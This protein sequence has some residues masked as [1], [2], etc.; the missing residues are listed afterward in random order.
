LREPAPGLSGAPGPQSSGRSLR[1]SR[2]QRVNDPQATDPQENQAANVAVLLSALAV[3]LVA[4]LAADTAV[5][6]RVTDE[7]AQGAVVPAEAEAEVASACLP[8]SDASSARASDGFTLTSRFA[9]R[10][11]WSS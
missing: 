8:R 6:A 3:G 7:A 1:P 2:D 5:V 10:P 11:T 4:G 9:R